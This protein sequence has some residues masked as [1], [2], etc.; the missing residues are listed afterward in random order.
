MTTAPNMK[1]ESTS[2]E[3]KKPETGTPAHDTGKSHDAQPAAEPK[4]AQK[5]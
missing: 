1:P 2:N 3:P 5:S 4:P